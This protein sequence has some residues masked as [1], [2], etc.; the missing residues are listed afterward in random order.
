MHGNMN[1]K[2]ITTPDNGGTDILQNV[3]CPD[4][5]RMADSPT[6]LHTN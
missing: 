1:L 3:W 2:F 5:F 6:S 4:L